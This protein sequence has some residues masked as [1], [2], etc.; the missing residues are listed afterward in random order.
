MDN[1]SIFLGIIF[2]I[3]LLIIVTIIFLRSL[4]KDKL[5][6]NARLLCDAWNSITES[7]GDTD[8]PPR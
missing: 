8:S 4:G 5:P 7:R 6:G 2:L 1:L 3:G